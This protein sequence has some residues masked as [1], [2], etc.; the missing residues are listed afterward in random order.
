M[1]PSNEAAIAR[2][3]TAVDSVWHAPL[4]ARNYLLSVA[5]PKMLGHRLHHSPGEPGR[6]AQHEAQYRQTLKRYES[7]FDTP[8]RTCWYRCGGCGGGGD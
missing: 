6:R 5:C 1:T 3:N 8:P 2:P 4:H 7:N